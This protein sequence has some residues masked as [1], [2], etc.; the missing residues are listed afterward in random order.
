MDAEHRSRASGQ[1]LRLL[2]AIYQEQPAVASFV[3]ALE[4][5]LIDENPDSGSL[6]ALISALPELMR[7]ADTRE[8]FLPWLA[9][10]VGLELPPDV[11]LDVQR[12]LVQHA[13]PLYQRRGTP[14]GLQQ[15]L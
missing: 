4:S 13:V 15:V 3:D 10:W 7:P 2:P 8:E 12:A 11:P 14:G 1:M 9:Q 5:M 6:A